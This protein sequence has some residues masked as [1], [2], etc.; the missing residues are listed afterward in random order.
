M[1][2]VTLHKKK[3]NVWHRVSGVK[4]WWMLKCFSCEADE[5]QI[6]W[7]HVSYVG[8]R[9]HTDGADECLAPSRFLPFI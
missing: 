4:A 5:S 2:Y 6:E 9:R 1:G 7:W 8:A 3:K